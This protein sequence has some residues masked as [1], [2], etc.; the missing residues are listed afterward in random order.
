LTGGSDIRRRDAASP[1]PGATQH[2]LRPLLALLALAL[3]ATVGLFGIV[4]SSQ[5]TPS[6]VLMLFSCGP[7]HD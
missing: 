5:N 6:D 3:A 1:V 7:C 2:R 4:A